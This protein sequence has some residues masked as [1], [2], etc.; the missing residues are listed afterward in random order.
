MKLKELFNTTAFVLAMLYGVL[1][2]VLTVGVFAII[3]WMNTSFIDARAAAHLDHETRALLAVH[4]AQG[5]PGLTDAV[6]ARSAMAG[7]HSHHY[8]LVD[9]RQQVVAGNLE[10]WPDALTPADDVVEFSRT[11]PT[12]NADLP[13]WAEAEDE[14]Y[15]V[16][17]RV[18]ALP[19]GHQLLIGYSLYESSELREQSLAGLVLGSAIT[20][21][22]ALMLGAFLGAAMLRRVDAIDSA[23]ADVMA[24]DLSRR[25]DAPSRYDE[26][27]QLSAR[28]N[29]VLD[30]LEHL[31]L[32]L[33][34]VA[35]N[36]S[37]DLRSPLY[38][39]RGRL[40]ALQDA[41]GAP[42]ARRSAEH[43]MQEIDALVTTL[44]ELLDV[45]R[46]GDGAQL[47]LFEDLDL[48]ALSR[49]VSHR[50]TDPAQRRG[51][52]VICHIEDRIRV[53]GIASLL[54]QALAHLLQQALA[55][56]R[57]GGD[58][59]L[60]VER[61]DGSVDLSVIQRDPAS[62]AVT[63]S[64]AAAP[65]EARLG[66]ADNLELS[67]VGAVAKLHGA[68]LLLETGQRGRFVRLRFSA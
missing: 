67:V 21:A 12:P 20:I 42:Q 40:E 7:L 15:T 58:V 63:S 50:Y 18:T 29:L 31:V 59:E 51:L 57:P 45:A 66:A 41:D 68:R 17:A 46:S 61:T 32:T 56:T 30:R 39:L 11:V 6:R 37:N 48:S 24:G 47:A 1:F 23:L 26:F 43:G 3:Y 38:R 27:G 52:Q 44:D 64:G 55:G 62:A 14:E 35:R 25:I 13:G 36:L 65:A 5:V 4:R 34:E 19:S 2:G 10:Q 28:I 8:L 16:A 53:R 54:S 33:R 9:A 49:E 22:L 60:R